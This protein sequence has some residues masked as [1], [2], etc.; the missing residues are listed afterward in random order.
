MLA[1]HMVEGKVSQSLGL[2]RRL[3][4]P[5]NVARLLTG[6][7]ATEIGQG[8]RSTLLPTAWQFGWIVKSPSGTSGHC[9]RPDIGKQRTTQQL[10]HERL[11]GR[12][13]Q[14]CSRE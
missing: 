4:R 1:V 9:P 14:C 3:A 11:S 6:E 10:A 13:G 7:I 8:E 12:E 2:R 5:C